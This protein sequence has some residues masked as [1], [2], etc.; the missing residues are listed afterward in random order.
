MGKVFLILAA[1]VSAYAAGAAER[2]VYTKTCGESVSKVVYVVEDRPDGKRLMKIDVDTQHTEQLLDAQLH[3]LYWHLVDRAQ[4]SDVLAELHDGV[5]TVKGVLRGR[6]VDRSFPDEGTPWIQ[7][8]GYVSGK[9]PALK[10]SEV[11]Y[12]CFQPS[13]FRMR[14]M[15]ARDMGVEKTPNGEA[16]LV[17]CCPAGA[18]SKLW[19]CVY[20]FGDNGDLVGYRAV[21]GLP[22]TP[23]T[24][25]TLDK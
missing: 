21:E 2:L 12:E 14:Q 8:M 4:D 6:A 11:A 9:L 24:V 7:N 18:L 22:G 19:S 5:F 17:K 15:V 1:L 16:T 10:G 3:T 20:L 13:N 23:L 25:W